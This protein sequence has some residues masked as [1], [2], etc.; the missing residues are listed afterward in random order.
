MKRWTDKYRLPAEER[1][2]RDP[3]FR[4]LVDM[5]GSM[6]EQDQSRTFTPT[7]VREAAMLACIRYEAIHIKPRLITQCPPRDDDFRMQCDICGRKSTEVSDF[8]YLCCM[9]QPDG[10][11]CHGIMRRL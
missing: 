11:C 1:Y 2:E 8:H 7:E 5:I 10:K 4:A 3:V 6:L 9:P